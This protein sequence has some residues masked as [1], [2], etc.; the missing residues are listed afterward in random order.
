MHTLLQPL[1]LTPAAMPC[2]SQADTSAAQEDESATDQQDAPSTSRPA[3]VLM[4][5]L[6]A[7]KHTLL[8][9]TAVSKADAATA[10][11]AKAAGAASLQP[12]PTGKRGRAT[13]QLSM[14]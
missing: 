5:P 13:V 7:G 4:L 2:F 12:G 11:A 3:L 6:G 1:P 9:A 14:P 10:A 8:P